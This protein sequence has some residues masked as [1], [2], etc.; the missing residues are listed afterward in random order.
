MYVVP[1]VEV[2]RVDKFCWYS[3][4]RKVA[5]GVRCVVAQLRHCVTSRDIAVSIPDCVMEFFIY[6]V[7]PAA[8]RPLGSTYPLKK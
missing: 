3:N 8:Q 4:D 1:V 5:F 6:T 7:L 2:V